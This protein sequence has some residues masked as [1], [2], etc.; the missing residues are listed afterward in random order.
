[1]RFEELIMG[2]VQESRIPFKDEM[3]EGIY[4]LK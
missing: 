3:F 4:L 1:M 2:V